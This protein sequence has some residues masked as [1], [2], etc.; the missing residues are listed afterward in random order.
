MRRVQGGSVG[1]PQDHPTDTAPAGAILGESGQRDGSHS[2]PACLSS[3]GS[4]LC[5]AH[6]ELGPFPPPSALS[7]Y[8]PHK[9][10]PVLL[11]HGK[12][13]RTFPI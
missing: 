13:T 1:S 7:S 3:P 2:H 11:T 9:Q 6:T 12:V 10:A 4:Y 5:Q 8:L